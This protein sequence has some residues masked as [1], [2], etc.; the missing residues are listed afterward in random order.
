DEAAKNDGNGGAD[1]QRLD[2]RAVEL[3]R[4]MDLGRGGEKLPI[5]APALDADIRAHLDQLVRVTQPVL[6]DAL[7]DV[8]DAFGLRQQRHEGGLAVRREPG[9]WQRLDID[10]LQLP[11]SA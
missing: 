2:T 8:S 4:A 1:I 7:M 3:H 11:A 9:V 10:G 6:V 5:V